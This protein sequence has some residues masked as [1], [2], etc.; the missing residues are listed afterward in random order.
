[1][2]R[3]NHQSSDEVSR[4]QIASSDGHRGPRRPSMNFQALQTPR[5]PNI[6]IEH[7]RRENGQAWTEERTDRQARPDRERR[8]SIQ[9]HEQHEN[10]HNRV[11]G[12]HSHGS[13]QA[14][15][16]RESLQYH[17]YQ[18]HNHQDNH[19]HHHNHHRHHHN[20]DTSRR[21]DFRGVSSATTRDSLGL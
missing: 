11:R 4:A 8:V 3:I 21:R 12:H 16:T 20:S 18:Y 6:V 5:I 7:A 19:H 9:T 2:S 10:D 17:D 1:M 15:L 14:R 13:Q